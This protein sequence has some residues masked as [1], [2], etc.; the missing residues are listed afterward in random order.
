MH[1]LTIIGQYIIFCHVLDAQVRKFGRTREAAAQAI[2]ICQERD[3]LADYLK[4]RESE[5]IDIMI[6][7]FDQEYAEE[8]YGKAQRKEGIAEGRKEGRK[9]GESNF[10]ALVNKLIALDREDDVR[11][12]ASDERYR[13]E[14]FQEFQIR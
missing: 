1:S 14:L 5:V 9:E 2:R 13:T 8:Q 4:G 6:M 3:V 12:A 10:A 7:L 11:R